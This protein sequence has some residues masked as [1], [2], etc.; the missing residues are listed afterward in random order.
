MAVLTLQEAKDALRIDGTDNDTIV[1]SLIDA[2]PDYLQATTGSTWSD[3]AVTGYQLAKTCSKF[4]I[5]LWYNSDIADAD[6]LQTVIDRIT[7]TL[8]VIARSATA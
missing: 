8:S 5:Q 1:Q 6:K 3:N 7:S 2:L 4:V